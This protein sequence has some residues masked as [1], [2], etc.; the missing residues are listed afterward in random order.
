[1]VTRK[2]NGYEWEVLSPCIFRAVKRPYVVIFFN[3]ERWT[4]FSHET[5]LF[6]EEK[7]E[8]C[9]AYA[10]SLMGMPIEPLPSRA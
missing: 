2:Y 10:A 4:V 8:Q 1:M 5:P 9:T 3:G 6:Q 7:R